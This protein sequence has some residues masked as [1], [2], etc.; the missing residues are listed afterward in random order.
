[1]LILDNIDLPVNT[2]MKVYS[3]AI[4]AWKTALTSVEA[5]L[6]GTPQSLQ[7]GAL[8]L[9]LSA[10]HLY[11]DLIVLGD[12]VQ[13][14]QMRDPLIPSGA[15]VTIGLRKAGGGDQQ[16]IH[17]SL[18]LAHLRFYGR[19]V[20]S[21]RS[22]N[23][24]SSRITFEELVQVA[25]SCLLNQWKRMGN[26]CASAEWFLTLRDAMIR[27]AQ[28]QQVEIPGGSPTPKCRAAILGSTS[29]GLDS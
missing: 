9:A 2:D 18:S 14:V 7:S 10:W 29:P 20:K 8:I 21:D 11:P 26:V 13:E 24:N 28:S 12:R 16:G 27:D 5:L 19:P 4:E 22:Y 6:P 25:F 23:R 3:S 17:R 1:M 15:T